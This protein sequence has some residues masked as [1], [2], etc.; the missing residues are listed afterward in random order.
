ME[1]VA[2]EAEESSANAVESIE[3][4]SF[5]KKIL[6]EKEYEF[7]PGTI[8]EKIENSIQQSFDEFL[9][10]KALYETSK[11]RHGKN[12]HLLIDEFEFFKKLLG[13][14]KLQLFRLRII[15]L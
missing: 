15:V 2:K 12:K 4:N 10:N 3:E 14:S 9:T 13:S 8:V 1:E 7:L 5:L 6:T 11:I